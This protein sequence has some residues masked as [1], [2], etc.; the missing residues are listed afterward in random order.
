M[1]ANPKSLKFGVTFTGPT[2]T[3]NCTYAIYYSMTH[4]YEDYYQSKHRIYRKGQTESCTYIYLIAEESIDEDIYE[5][6]VRKGTD[7]EII[8]NLVRRVKHEK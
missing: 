5:S 2:M 3:K 4:S 7:A 1:I 6:I 8:E